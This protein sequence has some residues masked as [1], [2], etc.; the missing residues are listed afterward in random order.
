MS[1]RGFAAMLRNSTDPGTG[2]ILQDVGVGSV[3]NPKPVADKGRCLIGDCN[4]GTNNGQKCAD[5]TTCGGGT[6]QWGTSCN[7]DAFC[8]AQNRSTCHIP[9]VLSDNIARPGDGGG[10]MMWRQYIVPE[11]GVDDRMSHIMM[12][13]KNGVDQNFWIGPACEMEGRNGVAGCPAP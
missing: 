13:V 1:A 5:S 11:L 9:K 6:C 4:G 3:S 8:A 2:P 10:S 7:D 12:V